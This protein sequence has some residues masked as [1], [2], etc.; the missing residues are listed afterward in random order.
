MD[1]GDPAARP[2]V[3]VTRTPV[4]GRGAGAGEQGARRHQLAGSWP[5]EIYPRYFFDEALVEALIAVSGELGIP[6]SLEARAERPR[7][8]P[9]AAFLRLHR[10]AW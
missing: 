4:R 7:G 2:A 10:L 9:E 6:W 8:E 1:L 3:R 5:R